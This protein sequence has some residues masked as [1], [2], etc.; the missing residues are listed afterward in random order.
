MKEIKISL[1]VL[2]LIVGFSIIL[3]GLILMGVFPYRN[4][5]MSYFVPPDETVRYGPWSIGIYAGSSPFELTSPTDIANPVL[6]GKDVKDI[7]AKYVADPFMMVQDSRFFLFFE[8]L[9]RANSQGDIGYAESPDGKKWE[10]KKII[11]DEPF[12]LS[13]PYVFKWED[14]YYLIPESHE[15]LSIRLYRATSF[16]A[17]WQFVKS[18]FNGE[19][20]VDPSIFRYDNTWWLF[21]SNPQNDALNLYYSDELMGHWMPHPMNPIVKLNRHISRPG[22][23][24]LIYEGHPYRFTQDAD[25]RYGIQVFA[26]E[27]TEL[28]K[29]AYKEQIVSERPVVTMTGEGWN[30]YGM[31]HVDSHFLQGKW[32]AAVDGKCAPSSAIPCTFSP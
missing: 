24:V 25:P 13:Y 22:G 20:Y 27:I 17:E 31:H 15:D 12:H 14:S 11:I 8:V 23:R 6:S 32:V 5:V 9:N 30:A 29:M 10:Y 4:M 2:I 18:I 3:G 26:F 7:D 16:P 28:S 1:S 21:Y 19:H